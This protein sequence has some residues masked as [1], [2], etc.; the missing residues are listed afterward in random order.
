MW[1]NS[2]F[3]WLCGM[4]PKK[5]AF[6]C[7]IQNTEV[8]CMTKRQGRAG[9]TARDQK[10]SKE[11]WFSNHFTGSIREPIHEPLG[12]SHLLISSR[13]PQ[14][15][16]MLHWLTHTPS[17]WPTPCACPWGQQ[18][19]V[20]TDSYGRWTESQSNSVRP[21]ENTNLHHPGESKWEP[22]NTWPGFVGFRESIWSW[23]FL[24]PRENK[25]CRAGVSTEVKESLRIPS[26]SER[27]Y[28]FPEASQ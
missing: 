9:T 11:C 6:A 19:W 7:P 3:P 2:Q 4:L 5:P 28:L 10:L 24:Y 14:A 25:K 21:G 27:R 16:P 13:G 18:T 22:V 12:P 1:V 17:P 26:R 15:P 23:E 20:F 8:S